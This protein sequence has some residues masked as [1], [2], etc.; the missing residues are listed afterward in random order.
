VSPTH[1]RAD[2]S[3]YEKVAN[4]LQTLLG[5]LLCLVNMRLGMRKSHPTPV[6]ADHQSHSSSSSGVTTPPLM[7]A[8]SPIPKT[9][10]KRRRPSSKR[11]SAR[12]KRPPIAMA[13]CSCHSCSSSWTD[14]S[15]MVDACPRVSTRRQ[16]RG[17]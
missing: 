8:T 17:T 7:R 15:R 13:G 3:R 16:S 6:C 5:L 4:M 2:S 1:C 9:P 10:L 11:R 14:C 12:P